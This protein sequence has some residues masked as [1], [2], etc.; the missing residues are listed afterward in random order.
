MLFEQR[1]VLLLALTL[2]RAI[3]STASLS[4][5]VD[6]DAVQTET[7]PQNKVNSL[8]LRTQG[9]TPNET[10]PVKGATSAEGLPSPTDQMPPRVRTGIERSNLDSLENAAPTEGVTP[11]TVLAPP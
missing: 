10:T 11:P 9:V 4:Q 1:L 5:R 3:S 8:E 2:Q 7:G 6:P